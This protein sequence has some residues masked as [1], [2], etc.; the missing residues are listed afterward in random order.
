MTTDTEHDI[1]SNSGEPEVPTL[2]VRGPADL[3]QAVP[4]LL[5]FHPV[6]SLVVVGLQ[7]S[8]VVVTARL[9]LTDL[10]APTVLADTVS[11]IV[12]SGVDDVVGVIFDDGAMPR[13]AHRDATDP[14]PWA[15]IADELTELVEH[16]GATI[17]DV[18]LVSGNRIW[19][20]VC[21]A[22]ECCPAEGTEL[23]VNWAVAASATYAG[24][25]ALPDRDS[26]ERI[27]EP[28]PDADRD[29]LTPLLK[30]AERDAIAVIS[31]GALA[32]EDRSVI[33]ALFAA[34]RAGD[35]P[36]AEPELPDERVVRFGIALQRYEVRDSLWLAV[37]DGRIDGRTLWRH[38]ARRLPA[39]YDAAPLFLFAWCS[40]RKGDGALASIAARRTLGSDPDYSAA[41][42][43][44]AALAQ[45]LDPRRLPKLRSRRPA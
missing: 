3:V 18:V 31:R 21:T 11:A 19:S 9:D 36:G 2:R 10:A 14:L 6:R 22:P 1:D 30:A 33:R 41:D 15:G 35:A 34:C 25:V 16:L 20:Y 13:P 7:R 42:L 17:D 40:Y 12:R 39:P 45:A 5:G 28:L 44:L 26:V 27:L 43:L 8:Q 24:L 23:E 38:V 37:D 4:Y 32:R 29:R